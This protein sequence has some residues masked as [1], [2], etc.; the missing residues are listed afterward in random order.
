MVHIVGQI[1]TKF[2]IME[3]K[4]L[5]DKCKYYQKL[6]DYKLMPNGYIIAHLDGKN[7]SSL[8]KNKFKLPFDD[9]F[10]DMMN[11]TALFLC[12]NVS[13]VKCAFVQSD[14]ISL[15]IKNEPKSYLLFGGRLNKLQSILAS[16][17]T[18]EFNRQFILYGL[19]NLK[20]EMNEYPTEDIWD[21]KSE[22]VFDYIEKLKLA[23]FDCKIWNVPNFN[24]ARAWFVFRF[25]DCTRNSKQQ[26][27][28]TYCSHKELL[29]KN[30]DAQ[31]EYLKE[32][33]NI[34]W[35]SFSEGKKF[36]RFFVKE[37]TLHQKFA[38]GKTVEYER[39]GWVM[40]NGMNIFTDFPS[41]D[42]V[43]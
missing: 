17:A 4:T 19:S 7:F 34:D 43:G 22:I 16:M 12:N 25:N 1:K 11:K 29:H 21:M 6:F 38:N 31:I 26:T 24:E 2:N 23:H 32:N 9:N 18:S 30:T 13:E 42:F 5:K 8:I 36:G 3:F 27:A 14:E 37:T 41:D 15:L 40:K 20:D 10:I 33:K 39:S 28:Q 35:N